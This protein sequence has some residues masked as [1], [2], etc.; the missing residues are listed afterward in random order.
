[1]FCLFHYINRYTKLFAT[2]FLRFLILFTAMV[3]KCPLSAII[4]SIIKNGLPVE[5]LFLFYYLE[6][7]Y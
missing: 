7:Q 3:N 6:D 2:D 5:D 1:M 4:C